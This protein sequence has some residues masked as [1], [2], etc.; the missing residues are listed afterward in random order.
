VTSQ[1][2]T[3]VPLYQFIHWTRELRTNETSFCT[4]AGSSKLLDYKSV[5]IV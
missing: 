4:L 2:L 3:P 5:T 1:L